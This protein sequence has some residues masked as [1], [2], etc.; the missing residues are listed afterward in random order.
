MGFQIEDGRGT[1]QTVGVSITGNRMDVS[2]RSDERIYYISRDNGDAY[3][4]VSAD[5]P[6]TAGEYNF[7]FKNDSATQK[8]YVNSITLG[9][10]DLAVWKISKVTGTASGAAI[11]ATNLNFTS[12]NTPSATIFGNAAVIGLTEDSVVAIRAT[13][14]DVD[15]I[16]RF[17]TASADAPSTAGEYNFYFKND[18]ATQKFYVNSITLGAADLAVWKISKVTGTAS[19]AAITATNLNFTSGNTPSATIFGNAAVIGLTEDSV[20]AIRATAADVDSIVRFQDT[21]ILG[22]GDAIAVEFDVGTNDSAIHITMVG[23]F[24]VE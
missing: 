21:L 13:A 2:S 24:D 10:A 4:V 17:H 5:A 20:V 14:A 18:S 11:T 6:S 15:S 9:A 19:G 23:F 22:R 8:F 1:G 12:G 7:Y 3:S 16:V